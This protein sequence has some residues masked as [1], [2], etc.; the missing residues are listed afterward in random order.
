MCTLPMVVWAGCADCVC[1]EWGRPL[2]MCQGGGKKALLAAADQLD[3]SFLG[4]MA[5]VSV[6]EPRRVCLG[7]GGG[8]G[9]GH[10]GNGSRYNQTM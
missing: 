3:W 8:R 2:H 5:D 1:G 7:G 4:D 6:L 10:S 9:E